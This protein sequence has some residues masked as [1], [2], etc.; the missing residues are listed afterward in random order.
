MSHFDFD[1]FAPR[2]ARMIRIL[3]LA[4]GASMAR[5]NIVI[6]GSRGTGKSSLARWVHKI[7]HGALP[8][9]IVTNSNIETF[10]GRAPAY[11]IEGIDTW[12]LAEQKALFDRIESLPSGESRWIV[13]T[14]RD[15]RVLARQELFLPELYYRLSV[16]QFHIPNLAERHED[17][18]AIAKFLV[19]V[20][21]ILLNRPTVGLT[22]GAIE[23]LKSWKWPGNIFE[24]DNVL[25]RAVAQTSGDTISDDDIQFDGQPESYSEGVHLGMKLADVEKKLILQTLELTAQNRTR[26]A[27]ILGISVRTLRNKINE[28]KEEACHESV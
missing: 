27:E 14:R 20:H 10:D 6:A 23:K 21:R 18:E 13:T 24:L 2:N 17:F 11:L 22:A 25:S 19:D 26:A 5:V 3:D 16:V 4:R 9:E 1:S 7:H 8:L 12:N 15:L 28:Y